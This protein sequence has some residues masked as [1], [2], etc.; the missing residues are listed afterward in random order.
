MASAQRESLQ[1]ESHN[2]I[3]VFPRLRSVLVI[4]CPLL[5][6][7]LR[8]VRLAILSLVFCF[9]K[10]EIVKASSI[11]CHHCLPSHISSTTQMLSSWM[12]SV[13]GA[14]PIALTQGE[15]TGGRESLLLPIVQGYDTVHY[16]EGPDTRSWR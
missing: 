9:V 8:P 5:P 1:R 13:L 2:F 10:N 15:A 6:W 11:V 16:G 4:G 14:F 3:S 7:V 12:P